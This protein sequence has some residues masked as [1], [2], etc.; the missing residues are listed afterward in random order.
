[1]IADRDFGQKGVGGAADRG[2]EGKTD[3]HCRDD[4]LMFPKSGH[5]AAAGDRDDERKKLQNGE[6]LP[7]EE[8]CPHGDKD[9]I[10]VEKRDRHSDGQTGKALKEGAV[11]DG[12]GEAETDEQG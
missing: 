5:E 8:G 1:M 2:G 11:V 9:G 3:S 6:G 12:D 10:N 7:K 4:D